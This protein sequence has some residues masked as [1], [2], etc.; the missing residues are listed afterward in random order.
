ML[1]DIDE[2]GDGVPEEMITGGRC[3]NCVDTSEKI[4]LDIYLLFTHIK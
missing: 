2:V 1:G 4:D 3:K